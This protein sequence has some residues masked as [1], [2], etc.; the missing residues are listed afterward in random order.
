MDP[1]NADLDD[2]ATPTRLFIV[3]L[4]CIA[5]GTLI[6][7]GIMLIPLPGPGLPLIA[8]GLALLATEFDWAE[9]LQARAV[10]LWQRLW[11]K[12]SVVDFTAAQA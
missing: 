12:P 3:T 10:A 4:K 11:R 9:A 1:I 6:I 5:G 8:A 2:V 7:T